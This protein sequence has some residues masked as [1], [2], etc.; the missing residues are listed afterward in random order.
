MQ[1]YGKPARYA[2]QR[3]GIEFARHASWFALSS[4]GAMIV[5]LC[6]PLVV[7]QKMSPSLWRW[8][9][10]PS[11]LRSRKA[12]LHHA[13]AHA[14]A[15]SRR[16]ALCGRSP[17]AAVGCLGVIFILLV[18]DPVSATLW[19]GAFA[20]GVGWIVVRTSDD[21]RSVRLS[22]AVALTLAVAATAPPALT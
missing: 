20:A 3:V 14:F 5:F 11:W 22:G 9:P 10:S 13:A 19:I 12:G 21:V 6:V 18:I 15:L 7:S 4:V 16:V 2:A 8:R 1:V 17:G